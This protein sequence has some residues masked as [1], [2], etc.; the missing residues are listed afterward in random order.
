MSEPSPAPVL[1]R[2]RPGWQL[3]DWRELWHFRD[4]LWILAL[5]D[6]KVRYK[7]TIVGAAW[8]VLQPISTMLVFSLLFHLM[9]AQP[10]SDGV[11][12]AVSLYCALLPWQLLANSLAAASESLV[13][14]QNLITKVY[15]PRVLVPLAP[16]LAALLDF[17]IAFIFLLVL[18]LWFGITPTWAVLAV[19]LLVA[20]AVLVALA[21]GLWCSALNAL[22]RDVRY[23]VPFLL[24]L[25]MFVS[26]VVYQTQAVVSERWQPLYGLNPMVGVLEGFRWALLG[27]TPPD[28]RTMLA[29]AVGVVLLL[30]GGIFYFRRVERTVADLV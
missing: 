2:R 17:A 24:Q 16:I 26:P 25:G 8:A 5:R 20:Y 10:I 9:K 21:A 1:I 28:P 30:L 22:Y 18:M 15:F 6:I 7:Q 12:Y 27:Q 3:F 14:N 13:V 19:P 29:S 4:L 23:V 11:P